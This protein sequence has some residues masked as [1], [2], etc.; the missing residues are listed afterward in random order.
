MTREAGFGFHVAC[1]SHERLPAGQRIEFTFH[2]VESNRWE[3][4]NYA[5]TVASPE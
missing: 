5:V 2:W 3:G 1:L 4:V